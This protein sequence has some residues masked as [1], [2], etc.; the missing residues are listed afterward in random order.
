MCANDKANV[1]ELSFL[2]NTSEEAGG[3]DAYV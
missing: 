3:F 2:L 1:S